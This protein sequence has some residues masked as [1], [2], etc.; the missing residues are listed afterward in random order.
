MDNNHLLQYVTLFKYLGDST[1]L[2]VLMLLKEEELC[3]CELQAILTISQPAVS[4][5]L[6][7]MKEE[8]LLLV[9]RHNQWLFYRLNEEYEHY[10]FL[11]N[12]LN[13]LP[14]QED[15]IHTLRASGLKVSCERIG[16]ER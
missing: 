3:V 6:R 15:S 5:Q 4:Q 13:Q 10:E 7:K 9:R 16:G 14:S 11:I 2:N 8:G 1:R 12:V